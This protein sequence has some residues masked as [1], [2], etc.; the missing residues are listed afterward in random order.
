MFLVVEENPNCAA[1]ERVL[2]ESGPHKDVLEVE[3]TSP[4]RK[5]AWWMVTGVDEGGKF[6]PAKCVRVDDSAD[7]TAWLVYGGA[8]GLRMKAT[9]DSSA[10][11]LDDK[12]Q[13][14]LPLLVLDSSGS[15]IKFKP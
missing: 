10:W 6:I 9:G 5:E 14:G 2:A 13:W 12:N 1:E 3:A 7:G 8:W 15:S 4:Q 11:S